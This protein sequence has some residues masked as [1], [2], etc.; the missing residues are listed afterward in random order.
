MSDANES[1]VL[2]LLSKARAGDEAA[3]NALFEKC[4]S[5]VNLVARTQVESWMRTKVD[6]SD[7]VQTTMLDAHQDF[8]QFRGE[9]EGEWLAWLRQILN[10]NTHDF[11]RRFRTD[12][13]QVGKEVRLNPQS[14]QLSA[15]FIIDPADGGSTP[16]QILM[17][18]E[19]ELELAE[20]IERLPDDYREVICLRNLQKLS[21]NDVA[22]R[23]GRSRPAT[24][25][26]WT[27]AVQKLEQLMT[28]RQPP[29]TDESSAHVP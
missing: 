3:R 20:A 21:F 6:A 25:M 9:S 4:R 29:R 23:M 7:L 12:K 28:E 18:H 10:H 14:P 22:E 13:R 1:V 27:R 19:Q 2:Q 11:I 8:D 26:L 5:Y 24:Q 16:S 17:Q 15:T